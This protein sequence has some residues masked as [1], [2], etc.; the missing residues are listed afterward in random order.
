[1]FKKISCLLI[2]VFLLL[3]SCASIINGSRDDVKI[4]SEPSEASIKVDGR[5]VGKT[6]SSLKLQRGKAHYFEISKSGYETY[7][8]TTGKSLSGWFWGNILCGGLIG[9]IVDLA[10]GNAYDIDPDRINVILVK[11]VGMNERNYF[12]NFGGINIF[13][14]DG[15]SIASVNIT[16]E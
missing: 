11:G 10:T 14:E 16:W 5:D 8:I 4:I 13:D 12:D 7:K 9:I 3:T 6:P 1:M 15:N 2:V